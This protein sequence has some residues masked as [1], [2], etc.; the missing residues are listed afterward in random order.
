L[1]LAGRS[2]VPFTHSATRTLYHRLLAAGVTIHE[3]NDS[4]LHAKVASIDGRLLLVGSYNL[5]PFSLAN[6]EVLV[7]VAEA[8]VV[9]Q[10][11]AWIQEHFAH[12]R[13]ITSTEE[14]T[15]WQR[16]LFDPLGHV[17]AQLADTMSRMIIGRRRRKHA[18][19]AG[20]TVGP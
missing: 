1:L 11:E 13:S 6:L 17:V 15:H 18:A 7:E 8:R 10:G 14:R 4:I 5:D 16:W 20:I 2:D 3:W 19:R 9:Q 12:S